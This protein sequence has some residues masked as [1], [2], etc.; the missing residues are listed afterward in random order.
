MYEEILQDLSNLKAKS[1][2]RTRL[3]INSSNQSMINVND[4]LV[5]NFA[6]NDYL[7]LS[8]NES[9]KK[10]IIEGVKEYGSGASASHLISGHYVAHNDLERLISKNLG[11]ENSLLF[12]SGYLA[13]IGVIP[14]LC[15]KSDIIFA[16][17]L[18][19]ASL[20]DA[21]LLSKSKFLRYKHNNITHLEE[22]LRKNTAKRKLIVTDAVFSMDGDIANIPQILDLCIKYDAY[23]YI[24]DAH[25]YGVI[26]SSGQGTLEYFDDQGLLKLGM[27]ERVICMI[28][29]GKSVGISGAMVAAKGNLIDYL[30]NKAKSY[31]YTTAHSPALSRGIITSLEIIREAKGLRVK[32][33][34]LIKIFR[35]TVKNKDMLKQSITPIQPVLIGN[36]TKTIEISNK[37]F[38]LG[39]YVPAIR[40]PTVPEGT[41]RLRVSILATH[42]VDEV[43]NLA[44]LING[45]MA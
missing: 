38:Q 34:E 37:L 12:S 5:V 27:K 24:D 30:V 44:K 10:S 7:G 3:S 20:N 18:N 16:D 8:Q 42:S 28:T 6:S 11:F 40:P 19:H 1:L 26:G 39:F 45:L 23:L 21:S 9:I 14:S 22:L 29:L 13:N 15:G 17:K 32:L 41:S 25:G 43:I 33:F 36:T 2:H 4:R 31:I 35:E